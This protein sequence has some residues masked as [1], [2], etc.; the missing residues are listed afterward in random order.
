MQ[1]IHRQIL[2]DNTCVLTFDRPNSPA[3]I[4]DRKT[5]EELD[6]HIVAIGQPG[7]GVKGLVLI[8]AKP[9][10]FVAGADLKA[11]E[12]MSADELSAFIELG[13][14][15]FSRIAA[16]PFPTAAAIHGACVGGGFEVTLACD[17]RVAS[18]DRA[19]KIGLPET[20]LGILPAWG[21]STRLPRLIGLPKAL[22]LILGGKTYP[23]KSALRRGLIDAVEVKEHLLEAAVDLLRKGKRQAEW[24]HSP[25][26]SRAAGLVIGAK[27]RGEVEKR[28]RGHYPAVRKALDVVLSAAAAKDEAV[29]L[30]AEREAVRELAATPAAHNL[31]RLFFLQERAKK[32]NFADIPEAQRIQSA[33]VIGAGVMGSGIVQWLSARGLRVIMRDVAPDRVAAGMANIAKLYAG[34]LRKH[35]FNAHEAREGMDRISPAATEVPLHR[36]DMVIEAAVEKMDVKKSI[37]RRLDEQVREDA[38]LATNTSALSITELAQA[39]KHPGRVVGIHF[40][41]PVHQMQ[42][43]EVVIGRDTSAEVAQRALRFVQK[44]GKLPVL[45]K[46][47][48][49]FLV[50]RI[51]LPYMVEAGELFW[52]GADARDI[53]EAM[54]DFGMPM[55]PLRLIDEV[56]VDIAEDV[57]RTLAEAFPD[58]MKVPVL[59]GKMLEVKMLG[60]K[61]GQ[62]F[63]VHNKGK[64]PQPNREA[65][66]LRPQG[67][68]KF[69]RYELQGRMVLLMVNEAARCLEEGIVESASDVDFGMVMGTGFAPFRGGPLRFADTVGVKKVAEDL[70]QLAESVGPHFAPCALLAAKANS[71]QRFHED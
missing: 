24:K 66:A 60:R 9:S 33:A 59:L 50:N 19:T 34:G 21:G 23:A 64:E 68:R 67:S 43:V 26:A 11:I 47:S 22:D 51:L 29:G 69:S 25:I 48:P 56:G 7:L 70:S 71:N 12:Q 52:Q 38:I 44:I 57:A 28:T 4:F 62:G 8:S 15:V 30:K 1:T 36:V 54:L 41:N 35:L 16:L 17:W 40:F 65:A 55:G 27:A 46:D 53:D 37:F 58:R 61:T 6:G 31:I 13:Q 42:L 5:L 20:K 2:D 3:N 32:L 14:N 49:G 10:I 39:T 18:P 63:Y 45:V